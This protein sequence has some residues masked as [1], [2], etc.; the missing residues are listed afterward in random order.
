M[1][2]HQL[3]RVVFW[4]SGALLSFCVMA[5]SVRGLAGALSIFEILSIRSGFGVLIL[6]SVVLLRPR[7]RAAIRPRRMG[8]HLIRN[9]VHYGSQY[10]WALAVTLLPFATV[11]A[12]EFTM[13]AWTTLLAALLLGERLSVSRIGAVVLG[14]VGVI[15]I[16]R[17]G[18]ATF[19][20]AALLVLA[21]AVGYAACNI[22][23][24][25]LTSTE[26]TFAIIFWMNVMQLPMGLAGSDPG[27]LTKLGAAEILPMFGIGIAGLAAHYCLT[28]ALRFGDASVVVPIDFLRI[29]LI[30]AIGWFVYGETVELAVYLGAVI[31][32]VGVLWNLREE[33][34]RH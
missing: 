4:M 18:L 11:F 15:V 10:A 30:A 8:M 23:T 13:P 12:L 33:S 27:F 20:P 7:L 14:I 29:P 5:V 2:S 26:P 6:T 25:S 22:A 16:V 9:G 19:Q 24:K 31:I 28:N 1:T 34:F 21:A 32:I 17:P 3:G